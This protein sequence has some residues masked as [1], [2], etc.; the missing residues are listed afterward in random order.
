[1]RP[2]VL[3]DRVAEAG[4]ADDL[5][6]VC[7]AYDVH[8]PS[9]VGRLLDA[10]APPVRV[11]G[12]GGRAAG[13]A[14]GPHLCVVECDEQRLGVGGLSRVEPDVVADERE[15]PRP[16]RR[17]TS[18]RTTIDSSRPGPTPMTEIG[19]DVIASTAAT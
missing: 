4:G 18:E 1:M 9:L 14:R 7:V 16:T 2:L 11:G 5:A 17:H 3:Q 15:A 12:S 19:T 10:A 6:A 8:R 13:V